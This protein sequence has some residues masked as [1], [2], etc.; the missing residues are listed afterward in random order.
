MRLILFLRSVFF[1]FVFLPTVTLYYSLRVIL[2]YLLSGNAKKTELYAGRWARAML[3][4]LNVK[5]Q[6]VGEERIPKGSCLFL[7]NHSSFVDIF[8]I[9]SKYS[10]IKFGAKI[11][12]FAIPVFGKALKAIGMLP[13]ARGNREEVFRVYQQAQQRVVLGEQFALAPEG[14]RNSSESLKS[15]KAGPF[16][17]AINAKIPVV[18]VVIKGAYAVWNSKTLLP[19]YQNRQS[20]IRVE[21][22]DPISTSTYSLENRNDLQS[23]VYSEMN[24]L[25]TFQSAL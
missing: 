14:G 6:F 4:F 12:L 24:Y 25:L 11:E 23:K 16:I 19:Q 18:P 22:L 1:A 8:V 5:V 2:S 3:W 15:F 17:F 13:I 20:E 7:F 9:A 21:F 10:H